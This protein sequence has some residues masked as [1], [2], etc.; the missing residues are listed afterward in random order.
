M[1]G[2]K[3]VFWPIRLFV[4]LYSWCT[5]CKALTPKLDAIVGEKN[6]LLELAKVDVDKN[7]ELAM[8]YDVSIGTYYVQ[9]IN[10]ILVHT[11]LSITNKITAAMF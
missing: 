11:R 7:P 10:Y 9:I 4:F 8:Q 1:Q 3:N 2:G 6:G 5:P